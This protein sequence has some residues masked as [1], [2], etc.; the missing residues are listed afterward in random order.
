MRQRNID[1][2]K[3]RPN[4]SLDTVLISHATEDN[5]FTLWLALQLAKE[6][7]RVWCDLTKLLGG[8]NFWEL[9]KRTPL[10]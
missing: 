2:G 5:E 4:V 1:K 3:T 7:Y 10:S 8:E 9:Q 6:G